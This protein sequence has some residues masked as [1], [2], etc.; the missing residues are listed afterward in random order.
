MKVE[1]SKHSVAKDIILWWEKKRPIYNALIMTLSIFLI[2]SFWD[3]PMRKIIG[4][5]QIILETLIFIFGA[6]VCYSFSWILGIG[7]HYVFKAKST[8]QTFKWILF[9][10]GTILSLIWTNF[11]FVLKFDVL[12]AN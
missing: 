2:Y 12:F 11:H 4:G 10:L 6:N 5:T 8:S 7:N 9:I 1:E 3:Y